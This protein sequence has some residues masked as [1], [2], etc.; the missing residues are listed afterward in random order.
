[1]LVRNCERD[2]KGRRRKL[3]VGDAVG[4]HLN[5]KAL[6][7]ADRLISGV[8]VAHYAWQFDRLRDPTPVFFP[9]KFDRQ[10]HPFMIR[11]AENSRPH[12]ITRAD[13]P[14][15]LAVA[16]PIRSSR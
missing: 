1:L 11:S 3:T 6:R 7:I 15:V 5:G 9:I 16:L 8:A 14:Q 12:R 13:Y 2:A 10:F 4:N